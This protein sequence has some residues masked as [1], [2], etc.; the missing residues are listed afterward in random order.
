MVH[1]CNISN[2]AHRRAVIHAAD[3]ATTEEL[4][5]GAAV[6]HA[7]REREFAGQTFIDSMSE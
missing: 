2:S 6:R 1:T 3:E 7:R 4:E 5:A